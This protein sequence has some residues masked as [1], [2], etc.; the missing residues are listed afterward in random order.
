M[1]SSSAPTIGDPAPA[2]TGKDQDGRDVSLSSYLGKRV[3]LF[4]YPKASTPG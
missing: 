1:S 2:F 3:V 4:F